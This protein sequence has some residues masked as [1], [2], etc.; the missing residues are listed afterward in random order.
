MGEAEGEAVEFCAEGAY[1]FE[2][3]EDL[4]GIS[5]L[6]PHAMVNSIILIFSWRPA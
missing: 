5:D 2:E 3:K 6:V 4:E 1:H